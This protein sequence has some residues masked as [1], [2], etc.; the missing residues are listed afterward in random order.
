[1]HELRFATTFA[2]VLETSRIRQ[3]TPRSGRSSDLRNPAVLLTLLLGYFATLCGAQDGT[4]QNAQY[5]IAPPPD[6]VE[7]TTVDLNLPAPEAGRNGGI[8]EG[9]YYRLVER[10]VHAERQQH[11]HHYVDEFLTT[12]GLHE[13]GEI[14][15]EF[16]PAYQTLT[17]HSVTL[18]RGGEEIDAFDTASVRL[19]RPEDELDDDLLS[20]HAELL[21]LLPGAQVGDVLEYSYTLTGANPF[22]GGVFVDDIPLQWDTTVGEVRYRLLKSPQ[23]TV[24]WKNHRSGIGPIQNTTADGLDEWLWTATETLA[25]LMEARTPKWYLPYAFV[26]LSGFNDW[27]EVARLGLQYYDFSSVPLSSGLADQVA[28]ISAR[29]S[30]E[31]DRAL[32]AVRLVQNDIRYLGIEDGRSAFCPAAP[33][34][35]FMRRYGDC[36]DKTVLLAR[37]LTELG[38][39]CTPV[40]INLDETHRDFAWLPSPLAFDHVILRI[41]LQH[42][43]PVWIDPTLSNQGGKL[44]D[45]DPGQLSRGLPLREDAAALIAIERSPATQ[46]VA[47]MEITETFSLGDVGEASLLKVATI[48]RGEEADAVRDYFETTHPDVAQRSHIAM[49][50][51][52]FPQLQ[53]AQRLTLEDDFAG[54]QLTVSESYRC[55]N[56]WSTD[57]EA[58]GY[59]SI[60]FNFDTIRSSLDPP[61]H[62]QRT[63][64]LKID[65]PHHIRQRMVIELPQNAEWQFDDEDHFI[66]DN[67]LRFERSVRQ[68]GHT[69]TVEANFRTTADSLPAGQTSDFV[70]T[71]NDILALSNYSIWR[72]I[73]NADQPAD[74]ELTG[75]VPT[76][77]S[78]VVSQTLLLMTG[79]LLTGVF[80]GSVF[81]RRTSR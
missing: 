40:Y 10:Q 24:N 20:G 69:L 80:I 27:N 18:H 79:A 63:M 43:E 26:Q 49:Y 76:T 21:L 64:P 1:M 11:Y 58:D 54:N 33:N 75:S 17:L 55:E 16:D 78:T 62:L 30:D 31:E 36:K 5:Q 70:A 19:L 3:F 41:D 42:G 13:N 52:D 61:T 22:F 7:P 45:L 8:S 59:H 73:E 4:T 39:S 72:M 56:L 14:S 53:I 32:M 60:R 71:T 37:I 47:T 68:Q 44:R 81:R 29:H 77:K 66:D 65:G 15:I 9:I 50:H 38:I 67:G 28:A 2:P 25:V 46:D 57:A 48:Y 34:L 12:A 74:S 35:T 6:W 51:D 23:R